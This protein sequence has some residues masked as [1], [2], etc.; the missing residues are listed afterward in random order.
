ME[1]VF[2]VLILLLA[3]AVSGVVARLA[4]FKLPLPLFQIALGA[5]LA[6]PMFGLRISFDPELF[7]LLFIPPLLFTDGW[8]MPKREFFRLARPIL[9][10]ALG[11]VMFTVVG[12]GY[13]IHWMIPVISLPS[14]FAL[15]A[16][17]S[18][19]DAVAVSSI[20]GKGRLPASMQHVLE[21]EA[22]MNDASGLVA[23]KF[24]IAA[25]ITG[26]F[27]LLDA[28]I[29]F[30]LIAAGGIAVGLI[31]AWG[32]GLIRRKIIEWAGDEPGIQVVLL[33]LIPFTAYIFAEH[34][35]LSG[36]LAAVAGGM[37]M[38]YLETAGGESA[39]TRLQ[40]RSILTML[41]FVFNGMSFLLLG[42]QLPG[43][44]S[45][46]HVDAQMAGNVP[47]WH[48][49]VYI[50][51]ITVAL[52]V[53]RFVWVWI[54]LRMRR[55]ASALRGQSGRNRKFDLR[56]ISITALSGVRGAITLAGVMSIPLLLKEHTPFP[57]RDLL[58]FLATGVI[59]CSLLFGSFLLPWLLKDLQLDAEVKRRRAEEMMARLRL[60]E[61]AVRSIETAQERIGENLDES[62]LALLMEVSG[63]LLAT[64]RMRMNAESDSEETQRAAN[65]FKQFERE[66][67]LEAV[68]AERL[69]VHYLRAEQRIND[70]TFLMLIN[71]IDMAETWLLGS[72]NGPGQHH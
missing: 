29:S 47:V 63:S 22:L 31:V 62:D 2:T 28:S 32:F 41:E 50:L 45:L 51:A 57:A 71:Q 24:A 46:A 64:Y 52:I 35:G 61:A 44:V 48:L 33:L 3:V 38:P 42:L 30:V 12:V 69:E 21:G 72:L 68:R 56:L 43:I 49:F 39:A 8:R 53:L 36:I 55:F 67:R 6:L 16:V 14:A 65:R 66:L 70:E 17:L 25:V 58:I 19:T 37:L 23:F 59:I 26:T 4:P 40:G 7:L 9:A 20:V 54:N 5:V 10:L 27:S 15:A 13:F 18:P 1:I 11:L 34:F 60:S